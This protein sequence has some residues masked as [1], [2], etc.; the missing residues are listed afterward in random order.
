M[1]RALVLI[2]GNHQRVKPDDSP[3]KAIKQRSGQLIGRVGERMRK[4]VG[5]SSWCLSVKNN[6]TGGNAG[7]TQNRAYRRMGLRSRWGT[8]NRD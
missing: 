5:A 3:A 4:I 7:H 1:Q 2:Q 8:Y 6:L